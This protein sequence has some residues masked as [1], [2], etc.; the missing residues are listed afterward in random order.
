MRYE[1]YLKQVMDDFAEGSLIKPDAFPVMDLYADQ[2]AD[3]FR[4]QLHLYAEDGRKETDAAFTAALIASCVKRGVLPRPVKKKY[5]RDHTGILAML[6]YMKS[7]F[8][9]SEEERLMRPFVKNYASAFDDKIDFHRLYAAIEPVMKRDR[10]R[11]SQEIRDSVAD[12]KAA[13]RGE[14]LEDDD[15]TELLLLFLSLA[16][17]ADTAR[18]AARKLLDEYFAKPAGRPAKAQTAPNRE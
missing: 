17:R 16:A 11:L 10:A 7:V 1:E 4:E 13:I 3:F 14:G 9:M 5:T 2:V 15:N 8:R 6:F 18:Y 12:V